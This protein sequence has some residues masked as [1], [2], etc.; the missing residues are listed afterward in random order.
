VFK[1]K[2]LLKTT[3]STSLRAGLLRQPFCF[4]QKAYKISLVETKHGYAPPL[5]RGQA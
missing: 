3:H 2:A 5:P 1:A 4:A